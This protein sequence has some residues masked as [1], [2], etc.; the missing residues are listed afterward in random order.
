MSKP[1]RALTRG[2]FLLA[3]GGFMILAGICPDQGDFV[4]RPA[5]APTTTHVAY[6]PNF[7][8]RHAVR[9]SVQPTDATKSV[10]SR[11]VFI[12]TIVD[13]EGKPRR[14]RRVEWILEGAGSIVEVDE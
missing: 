4:V 5:S 12:A 13:E 6:F 3:G 2:A 9:L 14:N 8:D 10:Q 7:F 1:I 11:Q